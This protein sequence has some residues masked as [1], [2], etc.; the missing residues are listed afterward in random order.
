MVNDHRDL[1]QYVDEQRRQSPSGDPLYTWDVRVGRLHWAGE[2]ESPGEGRWVLEL[3]RLEH[4]LDGLRRHDEAQA[5]ERSREF[6]AGYMAA[7]AQHYVD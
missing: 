7:V 2:G 5:V 6:V 4:D 1:L 3:G